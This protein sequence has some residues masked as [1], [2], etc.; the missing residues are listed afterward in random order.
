MDILILD[1]IEYTLF[2]LS[3][4]E[5]YYSSEHP[6]PFPCLEKSPYERIYKAFVIG[7]QFYGYEPRVGTPQPKN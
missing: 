2:K 1:G 7:G 6:M 4:P 3:G 5:F